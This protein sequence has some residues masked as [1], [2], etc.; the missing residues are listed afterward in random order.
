MTTDHTLPQT[1]LRDTDVAILAGGL[2]TRIRGVLGDTPKTLAA[3]GE[4]PF[5]AIL[6]ERLRRFDARR[7]IL[8]LGVGAAAIER[9]LTHAPMPGLEIETVAEPAPLGTAG[10][11][12]FSADRLRSDPVLIMNGDSF[13]DADLGALVAHHRQSGA[14]GTVL[15]CRMPDVGRYGSL[16]I[17]DARIVRFS[18]KAAN[19]G[20]GVIN[21]GV[22]V[23][24]QALLRHL[25]ST[26]GPS[27]E[28]DFLATLPSRTLGAYVTTGAFIDIGTPESLADAARVLAPYRPR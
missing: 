28:R 11:I 4:H 3:V 15:G 7:I 14:P 21:A 12:R 20:A 10:A 13:I 18:E 25:M 8:C 6:L 5:L 2:G 24:S 16:Q 27:L 17:E 26:A 19:A 9:Y 22:Y 23:F 1:S